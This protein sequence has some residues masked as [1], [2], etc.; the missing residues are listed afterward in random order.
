MQRFINVTLFF[1]A[2]IQKC[3]IKKS[4]YSI[5]QTFPI[6]VY[7]YS[8]RMLFSSLSHSLLTFSRSLLHLFLSPLFS[9]A[10]RLGF[11]RSLSTNA[12]LSLRLGQTIFSF[13]SLLFV[14]LTSTS[15]TFLL[16][17][18]LFFLCCFIYL[19]FLGC[20]VWVWLKLNP[21]TL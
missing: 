15:A 1:I 3:Y 18:Q 6:N 16:I 8:P 12:S 11:S 2:V 17:F 4:Y 20:V 19:C 10:Q 13:A 7:I 21:Q 14:G 9:Q 5:F